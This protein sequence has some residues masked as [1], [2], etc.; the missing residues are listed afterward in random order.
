MKIVFNFTYTLF[1][2]SNKFLNDGVCSIMPLVT[3]SYAKYSMKNVKLRNGKLRHVEAPNE[4]MLKIKYR[5][6]E[7]VRQVE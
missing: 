4:I 2:A 5:K 1:F 7:S 3:W 6:F